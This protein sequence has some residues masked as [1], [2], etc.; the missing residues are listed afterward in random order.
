MTMTRGMALVLALVAGCETHKPL[1]KLEVSAT[2]V[3]QRG[4]PGCDRHRLR[5]DIAT[6][7]FVLVSARGTTAKADERGHA[8][9]ELD[10]AQVASHDR[11]RVSIAGGKTEFVVPARPRDERPIAL[12]LEA[13]GEPTAGA[14]S[15]VVWRGE[16]T[17]AVLGGRLAAVTGL[18]DGDQLRFRFVGCDL[19][20]GT[21]AGGTV[22][23][24]RFDAPFALDL[25][26]AIDVRV[27]LAPELA[28]AT[29]VP[30]HAGSLMFDVE[31]A[32]GIHGQ[33]TLAGTLDV[34][35]ARAA[36]APPR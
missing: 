17:G 14:T 20:G 30:A 34:A 23:G 28:A 13:G 9:I 19:K 33:V 24:L 21:T 4:E 3:A 27:P 5:L 26:D 8:T 15:T 36:L 18:V 16:A 11:L 6:V 29:V 35:A 7:S 12:G 22:V 2:W 25:P 10:R 1:P 32:D 31:N